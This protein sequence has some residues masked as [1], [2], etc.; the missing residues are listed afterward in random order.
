VIEHATFGS[1]DDRTGVDVAAVA[2]AASTTAPT[3]VPTEPTFGEAA[4]AG[5]R[6][7]NECRMAVASNGVIYVQA[8]FQIWKVGAATP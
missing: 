1:R 5:A 6:A 3:L 7:F 2:A 4:V 8:G